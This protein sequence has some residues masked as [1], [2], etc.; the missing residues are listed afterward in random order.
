MRK[1]R[2][3]PCGKRAAAVLGGRSSAR[4][5]LLCWPP[6]APQSP[7][8]PPQLLSRKKSLPAACTWRTHASPSWPP[9]S[10]T[11]FSKT[12]MHF[13]ARAQH[14][15]TKKLHRGPGGYKFVDFLRFGTPLQVVFLFV[16]SGLSYLIFG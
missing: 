8:T 1:E 6:G 7:H 10:L 13:A 9:R 5:F 12:L 4:P 2:R 16:G 15:N 11:V 14:T 3:G